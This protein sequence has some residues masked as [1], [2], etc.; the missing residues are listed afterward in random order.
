MLYCQVLDGQVQWVGGLPARIKLADG[1]SRTSLAEVPFMLSDAQ[2]AHNK[3]IDALPAHLRAAAL[4]GGATWHEDLLSYGIRECIDLAPDWN[5][6]VEYLSEAK[7]HIEAEKVTLTYDIIKREKAEV[8]QIA[9]AKWEPVRNSRN[10]LLQA[11]D[12]TQLPDVPLTE[13]Q[14]AA[15][16]AYRQALRDVPQKQSDPANIAWPIQPQKGK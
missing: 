1:S 14:K 5:P 9:A 6:E 8:A 2:K 10:G 13:K 7:V 16:A 11:S 15:W 12:W 3:E 4:K